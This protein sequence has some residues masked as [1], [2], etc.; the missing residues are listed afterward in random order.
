LIL[1]QMKCN[2]WM[3]FRIEPDMID[4]IMVL[5][6]IVKLCHLTAKSPSLLVYIT[7]TGNSTYR[8]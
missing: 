5:H 6:A 1:A 4:W 2:V 7:K 8:A 3:R